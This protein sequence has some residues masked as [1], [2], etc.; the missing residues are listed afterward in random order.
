[1]NRANR[2]HSDD[3]FG[4]CNTPSFT[5]RVLFVDLVLGASDAPDQS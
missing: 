2:R 3:T 5:A 4:F 1:M